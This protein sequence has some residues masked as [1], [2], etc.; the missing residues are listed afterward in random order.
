MLDRYYDFKID[1]NIANIPNVYTSRTIIAVWPAKYLSAIT[2]RYKKLCKYVSINMYEARSGKHTDDKDFYKDYV[3][4]IRDMDLSYEIDTPYILVDGDI[5]V[6]LALK[7]AKINYILY[8]PLTA[9][10]AREII[11]MD[12]AYTASEEVYKELCDTHSKLAFRH[13]MCD[14]P[15]DKLIRYNTGIIDSACIDIIDILM[16]DPDKIN[17]NTIA[18]RSFRYKSYDNE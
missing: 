6:L 8:S 12:F 16:S 10:I 1:T 17:S 2:E 7:D 11:G 15:V 18:T 5:S 4:F 3:E 14:H 9:C 13:I